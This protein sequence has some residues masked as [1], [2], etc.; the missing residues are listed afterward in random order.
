MLTAAE[1]QALRTRL[2]RY[3]GR[4]NHMYLDARGNVTIGVGHLLSGLAQA[5]SLPFRSAKGAL[6]SAAEIQEDYE[7]VQ[8]QPANR[9]ASFYKRSTKLTL[10]NAEVDTLT[11]RH[12]D[13][14]EV[15][16]ARIYLGF[17]AYPS[18]VKLALLDLVF[19]VGPSNLKH[20]W[21]SFNAAI[22][23]KDWSKAAGNSRRA[24]PIAA[25]R[26]QYVRDLLLKAAKATVGASAVAT[27]P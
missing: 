13:A 2:E 4:V 27:N 24:T 18:E 21:P 25:E 19:N 22:K 7:A 15:E 11:N 1:K 26:N 9:L 12:I 10:P 23:A 14:F 8:R 5:Q 20:Q 3:E 6:A 17:N 16:L